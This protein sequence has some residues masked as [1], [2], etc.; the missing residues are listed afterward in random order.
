MIEH[1]LETAGGESETDEPPEESLETELKT[2]EQEK[3]AQVRYSALDDLFMQDLSYALASDSYQESSVLEDY[4]SYEPPSPAGDGY[5]ADGLDEEAREMVEES[6]YELL[7]PSDT[8]FE[9]KRKLGIWILFNPAEYAF[10][11][12]FHNLSRDVDF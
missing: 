2:E 8:N 12:T 7:E 11:E 5:D 6:K 9:E 3:P 10:L 4:E 1:L